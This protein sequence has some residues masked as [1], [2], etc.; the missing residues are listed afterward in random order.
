M[1]PQH[2]TAAAGLSIRVR[3]LL[4]LAPAGGSGTRE[5]NG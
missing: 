2:G 4:R 3:R 1:M 5:G